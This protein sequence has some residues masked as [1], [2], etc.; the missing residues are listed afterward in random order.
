MFFIFLYYNGLAFSVLT[1][2]NLLESLKD[3]VVRLVNVI[4]NHWKRSIIYPKKLNSTTAIS[5]YKYNY[6]TDRK[7]Y[8]T[9]FT[10]EIHQINTFGAWYAFCVNY[11]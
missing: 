9:M 8:Y 11:A 2:S 10:C 3:P 4:T 7:F 1:N 6:F 5:H